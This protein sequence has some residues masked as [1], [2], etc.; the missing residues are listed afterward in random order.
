MG[1]PWPQAATIAPSGSGMF[2]PARQLAALKDHTGAILAVAFSP[3]GRVLASGALD[4]QVR[5]IGLSDLEK[6]GL[7]DR[8]PGVC[9]GIRPGW[10]HAR[11]VAS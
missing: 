8:A 11:F 2:K 7:N 10:D 9:V 5:L 6:P 1:E 4:G 3:D